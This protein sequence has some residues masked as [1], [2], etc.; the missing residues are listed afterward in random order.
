MI[1]LEDLKINSVGRPKGGSF[2][3]DVLRV[4]KKPMS[5]SQIREYLM[6]NGINKTQTNVSGCLCY[7]INTNQIVRHETKPFTYSLAD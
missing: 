7:L 4:F 5:A 1:K 2:V 3:L 6:L